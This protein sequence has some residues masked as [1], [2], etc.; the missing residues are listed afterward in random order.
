MYRICWSIP[1]TDCAG[2]GD[3]MESE[4]L[5]MEWLEYV[6]KE[7]PTIVHWIEEKH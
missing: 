5:V 1:N 4:A 6:T 2:N 7:Y 3:Y